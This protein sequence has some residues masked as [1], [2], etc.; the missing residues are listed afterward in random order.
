MT[1]S[2]SLRSSRPMRS[3]S[4]P[5]P[6][7]TT[8]SIC[9]A[10]CATSDTSVPAGSPSGPS[11]RSVHG[12]FGDTPT[13]SVPPLTRSRVPSGSVG[14]V[15]E[16]PASRSTARITAVVKRLVIPVVNPV[17]GEVHPEAG[18]LVAGCSGVGA[19]V[20]LPSHPEADEV[21]VVRLVAEPFAHLPPA[22]AEHREV[23]VGERRTLLVAQESAGVPAERPLVLAVLGPDGTHVLVR[24]R[25]VRTAPAQLAVQR[26]C[27]LPLPAPEEEGEEVGTRFQ[28]EVA[29]G[30]DGPPVQRDGAVSVVGE[31]ELL[32]GPGEEVAGAHLVRRVR[33]LG[34]GDQLLGD[35]AGGGGRELELLDVV[36]GD[37]RPHAPSLG[38]GMSGRDP[39]V[40]GEGGGLACSPSHARP[41]SPDL[42]VAENGIPPGPGGGGGACRGEILLSVGG[43]A[44]VVVHRGV[45]G[46]VSRC[47]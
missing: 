44:G 43:G 16:Q 23:G 46:P 27:L 14:M 17:P 12:G 22:E 45:P 47:L 32:T 7:S 36:T 35:G 40:G 1:R 13:R 39:A 5:V 24:R 18:A 15:A 10:N 21:V 37:G 25:L 11:G 30:G 26:E 19:R 34:P 9:T 31:L 8:A 4:P 2:S 33:V 28:A 38:R 29:V 20:E 3:S 41:R 6:H 42:P